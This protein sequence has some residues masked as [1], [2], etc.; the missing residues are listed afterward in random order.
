MT[1]STS[2]LDYLYKYAV[3]FPPV[4]HFCFSRETHKIAVIYVGPGQ[5]DK[6][7]ILTNT[8]GSR[9]FEE[10][11]AALGWQVRKI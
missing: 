2:K 9:S 7:S 10:F 11:V 1:S 8:F 6:V 4:G 3:P 5:E